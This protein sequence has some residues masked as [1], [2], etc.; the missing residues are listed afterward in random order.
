[1]IALLTALLL[2][3]Y[4]T[5]L[6]MAVTQAIGLRPGVLRSWLLAPIAG[7]AVVMICVMVLNQAGVPVR[8]FALPLTCALLAVST[9]V[10]TWRRPTVPLKRLW[11]FWGVFG[12]AA[13]YIGWQAVP[14]GFNWTGYSNGDA[15]AYCMSASRI[16]DHGF[17]DIPKLADLLGRDYTQASWFQFGPGL[18]RSGF[19]LVLAW[20]AS[21]TRMNPF[22]IYMPLMLCLGM[23]QISGLAALVLSSPRL[24]KYA[25]LASTL[26]AMSPLFGFTVIAQVGPQVG[27]LALMLGLCALT[28]Q[29]GRGRASAVRGVLMIA[30]VGVG[31]TVFYPE[32]LPFWGL[33]YIGFQAALALAHRANFGFQLRVAAI[34]AAVALV[35]GRANLL[36]G[37]FSMAFAVMFSKA[38]Q[39]G[40]ATV[41]TGFETFK[42]Q[43]GRAHV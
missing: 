26:F 38:T 3:V 18:Y 9:A 15:L 5:V 30:L 10:I 13:V 17:F 41:Y 27:G 33:S 6:G 24:W 39:V 34:A 19:D 42:M 31:L 2:F 28:L 22:A 35:V 20:A 12:F 36:R 29:S 1:M 43:I 8:H 40:E 7:L 16:M 21:L 14:Y 25:L 4:L 23:V 32:V 37:Y 11:P